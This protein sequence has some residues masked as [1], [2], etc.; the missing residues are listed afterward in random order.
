MGEKYEK[1]SIAGGG[2]D[3]SR[4]WRSDEKMFRIKG[5]GKNSQNNRLWVFG[6][7]DPDLLVQEGER[8]SRGVM[9]LLAVSKMGAGRLVFPPEGVKI[10]GD[11]YLSL[12]EKEVAPDIKFR[13]K[14]RSD[15]KKRFWQQDLAPAHTKKKR[16]F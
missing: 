15:P 6:D 16:P 8:F 3:L 14:A 11:A 10:C 2:L 12:L 4:V 7:D 13:T 5:G 1:K 9:V